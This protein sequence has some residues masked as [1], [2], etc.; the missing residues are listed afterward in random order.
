MP[1]FRAWRL[2]FLFSKLSILTGNSFPSSELATMV[3]W[4]SSWI[5]KV[6]VFFSKAR[7]FLLAAS[8]RQRLDMFRPRDTLENDQTPR[9]AAGLFDRWYQFLE[10]AGSLHRFLRIDF[11]HPYI[12][13]LSFY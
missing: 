13:A 11:E 8:V 10:H 5:S 3:S 6:F 1:A 2:S 12:I 9:N 4:I 7:L